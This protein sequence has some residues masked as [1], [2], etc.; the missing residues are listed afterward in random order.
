MS[1]PQNEIF[2]QLETKC[3]FDRVLDELRKLIPLPNFLYYKGD[4]SS[5]F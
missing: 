4:L 1:P 5:A 3:K 2:S